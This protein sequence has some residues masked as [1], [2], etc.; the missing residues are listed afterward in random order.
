MYY[1][2]LCWFKKLVYLF[3]CFLRAT[4]PYCKKSIKYTVCKIVILC[5]VRCFLEKNY[6][7]ANWT[8]PCRLQSTRM[9]VWQIRTC[10]HCLCR[11][12][13]RDYLPLPLWGK[14]LPRS[15]TLW[16]GKN[17]FAKFSDFAKIFA[18]TFCRQ[19]R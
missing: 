5:L 15:F 4:W 10:N 18:N 14:K 11:L 6:F 19:L 2:H 1:E 17:F 3:F 12:V 8:E 7:E 9:T 13:W 16:T